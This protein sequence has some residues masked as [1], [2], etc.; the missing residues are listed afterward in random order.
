ME[1]KDLVDYIA[2]QIPAL[3]KITVCR[4]P[5]LSD[6]DPWERCTVYWREP[7]F[8]AAMAKWHMNNTAISPGLVADVLIPIISDLVR[9]GIELDPNTMWLPE[10]GGGHQIFIN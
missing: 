10:S 9:R 6:F 1:W 3:G 4:P 5:P 2:A 7:C 8:C